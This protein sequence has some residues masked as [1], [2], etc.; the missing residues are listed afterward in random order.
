[1]IHHTGYIG[2]SKAYLLAKNSSSQTCIVCP[3]DETAQNIAQD[4]LF[5]SSYFDQS[6]NILHFPFRPSDIKPYEIQQNHITAQ[7]LTT[8]ANITHNKGVVV[9]SIQALEQVTISKSEFCKNSFTLTLE[10]QYNI[11]ELVEKLIF[12]GFERESQCSEKG[13]FS[14]RGDILDI[15]SPHLESPV[16][17]EFFG[18]EILQMRFYDPESQRTYKSSHENLHKI[19]II[20]CKEFFFPISTDLINKKIQDRADDLEISPS[21]RREIQQAISQK[22]DFVTSNHFLPYF[23]NEP[24]TFWDLVQDMDLIWIDPFTCRQ[25][26]LRLQQTLEEIENEIQDKKILFCEPRM[27]FPH[28]SSCENRIQN[29]ALYSVGDIHTHDKQENINANI[30]SIDQLRSMLVQ[31]KKTDK[32]LSPLV[33]IIHEYREKGFSILFVMFDEK[34]CQNLQKLLE[35]HI[36]HIPI[37]KNKSEASI[38][39][40][41]GNLSH[42]FVH[43]DEKIVWI[44]E[45]E[46]FGHKK[47]FQKNISRVNTHQIDLT[48]LEIGSP[49]VHVDFGIGIYKG[50]NKITV[51]QVEQDFVIIE[52]AKED[53][54]FLPIYRLNRI[55]PFISADGKKPK[56]DSLGSTNWKQ[57]TSKAKKAV[58]EMA[59]ELI[60]LYASRKVAHGFAYQPPDGGFIQFESL[61]PFDET[62]DQLA[63]ME[64]IEKDLRSEKPMDRLICGDVGF[65]KTEIALRTAY[66]VAAEGKQVAVLVPTTILC[67]Q[68]FET[69]QKRFEPFPIQV[70]YVSRFKSSKEN[71]DTLEKLKNGSLD[72]VIGTHR[73][74]SKDVHFSNLGLLVLDE[75]HRF[76]VKHKEKIKQFRNKID[77]LTLTATP[78]PR[79]LQLSM[80]GIRDL[81]MI[82]TPP[83]DRKAVNTIVSSFDESLIRD[84]ILKETGRGGQVYFL[85]N[86]VESIQSMHQFLQKLTPSVKIRVAHG[87]MDKTQLEKTMHDFLQN[88]FDVLLCTTIIESGIDVANA[89]TLI[90]NRADTF[91]LA[92]L[93]QL[94]GRVGRS[95]RDAYA[96]LL[97]PGEDIITPNALKR[98]KTIKKFTD[99]GSGLKI[100]MHD[101]EM[102][103]AGNLLGAKQSGHISNVGFELYIQLLERE[104]RKLKGE[105]ITED[106]E[107]ELRVSMPAY[108]PD[109]YIPDQQDRL[110]FY[111]R[112][113][114]CPSVEKLEELKEELIDRFGPIPPLVQNLF[115][116]IDLKI[117]CRQCGVKSLHITGQ[118]PLIEFADHAP[119]DL[120]Q[121]LQIIQKNRN[122]QLT[123]DQKLQM[124]FSAE[125]EPYEETKKILNSLSVHGKEGL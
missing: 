56:I 27:F 92:Q 55:H 69:F 9:T 77:V 28:L 85:H 31:S 75:E 71:K 68:H 13:T 122:I 120:N 124:T 49:V 53:K 65:G 74:L 6:I 104:I 78:I 10:H 114:N 2:S 47:H 98:L 82:N 34:S 51:S 12:I 118:N 45:S 62:R 1:M 60:K 70:G 5:F 16:R 20:P 25:E 72:I 11:D 86:R 84:V 33:N 94:R 80:T 101:L 32:P 59:Q 58:E 37:I 81:S 100:A 123:P 108:I 50:L 83:L 4:L 119:I 22:Q 7:R 3:N 87:Q 29:K 125:I 97:I 48:Q 117:L 36:Q 73:L 105:K 26:I 41:Q 111:R 107:P 38:S 88:K 42:G 15:F 112:L 19:D 116:V 18:D 110:T 109:M 24:S 79:T 54:L 57:H 52:Y 90:I 63:T 95:S 44:S 66:R 21:Q 91:G 40:M 14:L 115:E 23:Q 64:E 30:A 99:L 39:I 113:S 46:I 76:G 89:N 103:G 96:Y 8:I 17:A 102:R 35:P 67:Q 61:F 93:Y 106:V 43:H 121:L